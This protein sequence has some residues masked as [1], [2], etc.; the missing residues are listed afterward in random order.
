MRQAVM[1]FMLIVVFLFSILGLHTVQAKI[2]RQQE[3]DAQLSTALSQCMQRLRVESMDAMSKEEMI[4]DVCQSMM[5]RKTSGSDL[6]VEI[7]QIE[8]SLGILDVKVSMQ[9][10]QIYGTGMVESRKC[11]V[12]DA[13]DAQEKRTYQV[14]FQDGETLVKAIS[15]PANTQLDVS[16]MGNLP[17]ADGW[18]LILPYQG[19]V[20]TAENIQQI[21][22]SCDLTFQ[23][24]KEES[25]AT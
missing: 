18:Q 11:I 14:V 2:T 9:I 5:L 22:V 16:C 1:G 7:Y 15:W 8:E 3:L 4:A 21:C 23:L 24:R 6:V 19:G 13:W 20:Y 12:Y 25:D 10:S 17:E